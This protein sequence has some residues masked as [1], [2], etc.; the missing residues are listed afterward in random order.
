MPKLL[1]AAH[2]MDWI[3]NTCRLLL[4]SFA[5][6]QVVDILRGSYAIVLLFAGTFAVIIMY[7]MLISPSS[8]IT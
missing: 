7:E 2:S 1:L 6:A 5:F 8:E 3:Q 4:M